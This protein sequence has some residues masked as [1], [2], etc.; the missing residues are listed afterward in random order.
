MLKALFFKGRERKGCGPVPVLAVLFSVLVTFYPGPPARAASFK[1]GVSGVVVMYHRFGES[2]Y[3]STS[4]TLD[5]FEAQLNE[6]K[7]GPYKV[8]PLPGI[9][10]ALRAGKPLPD[11]TVG[12]S[13]D[14]AYLSVYTEAWPRLKAAGLPFTLFVATDPVDQGLPGYMSWDQIREMVAGGVT[15]AS[16]TASHPHLPNISA[17]QAEGEIE[18]SNARFEAELG[19][20][21]GLF[22]YPFGEAGRKIEGVVERAGFTAAFGQHSGAIGGERNLFYLPRFSM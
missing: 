16:Q 7:T 6:L 4:I 15:I 18:R 8:L 5:Q 21:P 19:L 9:V 20:R 14:D 10:S 22:A 17:K 1:E 13:I 2:R 3:P 12:L 11:R